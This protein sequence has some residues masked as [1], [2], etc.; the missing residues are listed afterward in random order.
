M[1]FLFRWRGAALVLPL[2]ATSVCGA[3]H[4][5]VNIVPAEVRQLYS[6]DASNQ[7]FVDVTVCNAKQQCRTVP[8]VLV[9]T[10]STGLRLYRGALGGL[11]LDEVTIL[12]DRPLGKWSHFGSG[13][14]WGRVHWAQVRIGGVETTEA[15]PI[16]LFD[17]PSPG[18][19][20]PAGY[21]S[22]DLRAQPDGIPGNGILGISPR[23]H[24][25]TGYFAFDR[26]RS[27][28]LSGR[29]DRVL[30]AES[31]Q[32]V[33]PIVHFPPPYDNGSVIR[34]PEVDWREGQDSAQ[35][36]LGFGIGL[37]TEVLFPH[38]RR[39]I[40]LELDADGRFP[41][42]L[43]AHRVDLMLDSGTNSMRLALEPFGFARHGCFKD[44]YDPAALTPID[45][46]VLSA[47]HEIELARPLVVGPAGNLRKTA[48]GYGV[49]PMLAAG[50]ELPDGQEPR[51]MLGLPFFYGRT[52]ATGLQGAVNP[53]AQPEPAPTFAEESFE[54][55]EDYLDRA[56]R[57]AAAPMRGAAGTAAADDFEHVTKS[58]HGFV[59]FTD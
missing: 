44:Y 31:V 22:V 15:I 14:L 24:S 2:V 52:V 13:D 12:G 8:N 38:G 57:R 53:Y 39:V 25:R 17:V 7:L 27:T 29:W 20:L 41:A 5:A 47:S 54:I 3:A 49:L 45:L 48:L 23:H 19:I 30:V 28:T 18:E 4:A 59:A 21:G 35:G 43:G 56:P 34:L 6:G 58:P 16:E 51:S 46:S 36:W 55:V 11:S 50:P 32:V 9:D 40:A 26:A 1:R 37:P 33:N 42:E 10:G